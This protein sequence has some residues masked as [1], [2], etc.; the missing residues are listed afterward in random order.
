M[1]NNPENKDPKSKSES[2]VS[3]WYF[4]AATFVFASPT[5][6]S[7]YDTLPVSIA[8]I[9]LGALLMTFGFF[10]LRKELTTTDVNTSQAPPSEEDTPSQR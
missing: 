2:S 7:V 9:T 1:T 8:S 3:V 4:I 6:F 5:L 10:A